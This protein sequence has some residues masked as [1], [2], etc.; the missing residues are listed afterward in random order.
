MSYKIIPTLQEALENVCPYVIVQGISNFINY[1]T[2]EEEKDIF[3]GERKIIAFFLGD[4]DNPEI[5][6]NPNDYGKTWR[7]LAHED[8][9]APWEIGMKFPFIGGGNQ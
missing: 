4:T 7:C 2:I 8:D 6:L 5:Q 9:I 1:A 3:T